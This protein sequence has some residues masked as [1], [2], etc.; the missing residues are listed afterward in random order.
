MQF[1]GKGLIYT[2]LYIH[3]FLKIIYIQYLKKEQTYKIEKRMVHFNLIFTQLIKL[4][5]LVHY[6]F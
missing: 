1:K 4:C 6:V 5:N 3:V 2:S